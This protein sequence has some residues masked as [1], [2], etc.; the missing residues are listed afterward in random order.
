MCLQTIACPANRVTSGRL[1]NLSPILLLALF[2]LSPTPVKNFD[3]SIWCTVRSCL[4]EEAALL[5][6]ETWLMLAANLNDTEV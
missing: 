1:F 2:W 3:F 4:L 6:L 5:L